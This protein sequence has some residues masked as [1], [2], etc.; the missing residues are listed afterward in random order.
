MTDATKKWND[1][2]DTIWGYMAGVGLDMEE[3]KM[4]MLYN[5]ICEEINDKVQRNERAAQLLQKISQVATPRCSCNDGM[6]RAQKT[7]IFTCA[8]HGRQNII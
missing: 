6:P 4:K 1:V 5:A 8:M 7:D 2:K 3:P